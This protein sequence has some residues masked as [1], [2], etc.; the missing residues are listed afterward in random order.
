MAE[1]CSNGAMPCGQVDD[2]T[3]ITWQL[4]RGAAVADPQVCF[5]LFSG[6]THAHADGLCMQT[7]MPM[8]VDC[9]RLSTMPIL[10][11]PY[12]MA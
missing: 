9:E 8:R 2:L 10:V 11:L 5:R 7:E 1:L 6:S 3:P 12:L 4:V